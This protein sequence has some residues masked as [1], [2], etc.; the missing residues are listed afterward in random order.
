MTDHL[1]AR[2]GLSTLADP[3]VFADTLRMFRRQFAT[4][5]H[6][7]IEESPTAGRGTP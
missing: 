3:L 4:L 5:T 2:A 1:R 7:G 6:L